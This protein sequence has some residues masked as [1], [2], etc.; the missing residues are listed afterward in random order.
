MGIDH[1]RAQIRM[2]QQLLDSTNVFTFF[3]EMGGK[4]VPQRIHTLPANWGRR[5]LSIG[6]TLSLTVM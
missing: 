2:S 5:E 1:G 4:T 3:Q 6:I